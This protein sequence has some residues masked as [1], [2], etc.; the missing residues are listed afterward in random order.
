MDYIYIGKIVNTH[1]IKGELRIIS[2]ME[3]KDCIFVKGIHL[4]IGRD[5]EQE[6]IATYRIHKT[7]DMVTFEGLYDI[8][9]V[10]PYKG[11]DVYIKRDEISF[12]GILKQDLIGMDVIA[13]KYCGKVVS[14]LK[15]KA[16]D[17]L[18][19][20]EENHRYLIPYVDAF[21]E[22]IDVEN[23]SILVRDM[24]GLFDEN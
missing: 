2:D 1:G 22:K 23:H 5:K 9:D 10:L 17:I 12:P 14:I 21:I 24:K 13:D 15:S 18:V 7:Y 20:E 3:Y 19:I 8:N 4:Y 6:T 16:H 11:E